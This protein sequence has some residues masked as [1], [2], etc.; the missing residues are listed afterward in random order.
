[1]Q[2]PGFRRTMQMES[3]LATGIMLCTAFRFE[4]QMAVRDTEDL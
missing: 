4:K 3:P 1:M 2:H